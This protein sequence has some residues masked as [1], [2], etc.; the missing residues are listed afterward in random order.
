[1]GHGDDSMRSIVQLGGRNI[2]GKVTKTEK[3]LSHLEVEL[4]WK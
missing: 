3:G 1:M 2:W 4:T